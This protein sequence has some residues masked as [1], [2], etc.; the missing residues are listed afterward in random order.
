MHRKAAIV[1]IGHTNYS[2]VSGRSEWQLATEAIRAALDDAGVDA[3]EVD[4]L[5]RYGYDNVT[6]V[7][8]ARSFNLPDVRHYA[9]IPLGGTATGAVI[10]Q[11]AGAIASGQASV[12]VVYRA[13][14]ERSGVRYGRADRNT[15]AGR[16]LTVSEHEQLMRPRAGTPRPTPSPSPT[17][18]NEPWSS[19]LSPGSSEA[20]TASSDTAESPRTTN[21]CTTALPDSTC[22]GCSCSA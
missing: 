16:Q 3:S 7:E 4:G 10:T 6:P 5:V 15:T 8:I 14:N 22:A 17:A 18:S 21:G 2:K 9:D 12:V 20:P 11:A 13:M 1:G 19:V